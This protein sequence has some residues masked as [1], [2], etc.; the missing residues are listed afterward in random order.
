V[1]LWGLE[2][3]LERRYLP[4]KGG[5]AGHRTWKRDECSRKLHLRKLPDAEA[6]LRR[7]IGLAPGDAE[8]YLGL[9]RVLVQESKI[10]EAIGVLEKLAEVEPKRARELYQRMAQYALQI[11][12][13]DDAIKYAARAVELNPDD[14]DGHRRLGEMYRSRQDVEHAI[15]EFRAAITKTI[16]CS[17]SISSSPTFCSPRAGGRGRPPVSAVVR[18]APDEEARHASRAPIHANQPRQ[19]DPGIAGTGSVAPRDRQ[20]AAAY[21]SPSA[22]RDLRQPHLRARAES[23]ARQCTRIR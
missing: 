11:Y 9:E 10:A 6:T 13:D 12:K 8:S 4:C 1:T 15:A 7:V 19:R 5:S 3:V 2:R 18:A 16:A 20:S 14:A 21:L 23:E 22:R 17:S